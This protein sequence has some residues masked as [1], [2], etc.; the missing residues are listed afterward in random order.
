MGTARRGQATGDTACVAADHGAPV[1][2]INDATYALLIDGSTIEIRAAR[3]EDAEAVRAM[4]AALSPQNAYLRFFNMSSL[5]AERE[6]RRVCREPGPDHAALLAW[7][8]FIVVRIHQRVVGELPCIH[9]HVTTTAVTA[10][11]SGW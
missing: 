11:P 7:R 6:A 9:Q 2:G 10:N 5:N 3:P 8:R 1:T 4:H